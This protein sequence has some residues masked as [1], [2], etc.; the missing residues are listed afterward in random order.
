MNKRV[1]MMVVRKRM[2]KRVRMRLMDNV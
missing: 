1:R 2:K